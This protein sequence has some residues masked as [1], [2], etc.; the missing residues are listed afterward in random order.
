VRGDYYAVV[1]LPLCRLGEMLEELGNNAIVGDAPLGVPR[2]NAVCKNVTPRGA[3][4]TVPCLLTR[5]AAVPRYATAGSAG[6]DVTVWPEEDIILKPG[7]RAILPTGI[8]VSLP[9]P[10]WVGLVTIRSGVGSRGLML[11]NGVGV[12]DSDYRG[13]LR[14]A[15]INQSGADFEIKRGDRLAQLLITPVAQV[16]FSPA[17]A[18][19]GTARGT[20]GYGSTGVR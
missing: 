4:P 17:D 1:G 16:A 20:G 3:S 10:G 19:D 12:I 2:N 8:S 14:L 11:C 15:V 7:E 18:L 9:G 6:A 5:D 13:E